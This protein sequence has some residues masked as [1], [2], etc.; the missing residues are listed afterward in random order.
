MKHL[1]SCVCLLLAVLLVAALG[2]PAFADGETYSITV[3][4]TNT[5]VTI[6]G[7]TYYAYKLFDVSYSADK[8]SYAYKVTSDFDGFAYD[9]KSGEALLTA[10][11]AL[12]SNS[13]EMNAFAKAVLAYVQTNSISPTGNV[14]IAEKSQTGTI[15]LSTPG[16][17]LVSGSATADGGQTIT[18]ACSLTTTAPSATINPKVDAPKLDKHIVMQNAD[19]S[20]TKLAANSANIGDIIPFE[21]T[22][23]VP[24]T[25]GYNKYIFQVTDT[26]TE[27][28]EYIE[29]SLQ[30]YVGDVKLKMRF[31]G[32][33][34]YSQVFTHIAGAPAEMK[35]IFHEFQKHTPGLPIKIKYSAVV[36][37][38]VDMTATGNVNE[39][40]LTY[41]NNPNFTYEGDKPGGNAPV[42]ETPKSVTK[43]YSTALR[44]AKVNEQ[45]QSLTGAKFTVSG[46]GK[47]ITLLN[48]Q[49]FYPDNTSRY[50]M[51]KDGTYTDQEPTEETKNAYDSITQKYRK[52]DYIDNRNAD[53][54][55][56]TSGYVDKDGYLTIQGLSDG[57]YTITEAIAPEGYNLLKEPITITISSTPT[58]EGPNW[59]VKQGETPL[60]AK[61][62]AYC[63]QVVNKT[64]TL[65][66]ATGGMGT[67]IF[68]LLGSVMA[69]AAGILLITKKRMAA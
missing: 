7:N 44:L 19:G 4:N 23:Q 20:T 11:E 10:L 51:L 65:L 27:G 8:S 15:S 42:G 39:A 32:D 45:G 29:S 63:F 28:M 12:T 25:T 53:V 30:V 18:A 54:A 36:T 6:S 57:T 33:N 68:Y 26:L 37:E 62:N 2:L 64:G 66:P 55:F 48:G 9:G 40:K 14:T 52:V 46:N 43:T 61:D 1:R 13:A 59:V 56:N 3:E 24:N 49:A 21:I 50:Y 38:K 31:Q 47:R 17:Y 34:T 67:T 41:S 16:Y 22:S 58:L 5:N 69:L 35:V 60:T